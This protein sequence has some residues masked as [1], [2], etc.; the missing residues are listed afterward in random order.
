MST[1]LLSLPYT[2]QVMILSFSFY[3]LWYIDETSSLYT[4]LLLG[5]T[6]W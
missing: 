5:F 1:K 2:V 3:I 4:V 6:L